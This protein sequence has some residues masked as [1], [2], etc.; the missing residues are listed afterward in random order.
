M[1]EMNGYEAT[2]KIRAHE[3]GARVPIIALTASNVKGEKERCVEAGM[4]DLVVKPFVEDS[5]ASTFNKW[6]YIGNQKSNV[7]P[8]VGDGINPANHFDLKLIQTIFGDDEET[9]DEL[10][11]LVKIELN[12]SVIELEAGI[13]NRDIEELNE[14]GHKLYGSAAS[15]GFIILSGIAREFENLTIFD[16]DE[17][18]DLFIK[19]KEEIE[20]IF[21]LIYKQFHLRNFIQQN[22]N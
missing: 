8:V 20:M 4:D 11:S 9:I 22:L 6:L 3:K 7:R 10:I 18:N 14:V 19:A 21:K 12:Q 13:A 16:E 17:I 1:P 5:I 15:S 2:M